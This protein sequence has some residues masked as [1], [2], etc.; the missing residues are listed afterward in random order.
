MV[1]CAAVNQATNLRRLLLVL[2][3]AGIF[4]L[5]CAQFAAPAKKKP[6]LRP[7]NINTATLEELQRVPGIGPATAAKIVQMRK[8]Y[9]TFKSV[10]DLLAIRGIGRKRLDKMRKYLTVGKAPAPKNSPPTKN[11]NDGKAPPIAPK[12]GPPAK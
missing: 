6:P 11:T 4:L 2:C 5:P 1:S 3:T 10:D 7:V 8:S 9:G 12:N